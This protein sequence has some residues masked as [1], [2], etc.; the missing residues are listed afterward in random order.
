MNRLFPLLLLSYC[1]FSS[2]LLAETTDTTNA[3]SAAESELIALVDEF[4]DELSVFRS[5]RNKLEDRQ[6]Q[7]DYSIKNDPAK[8]YLPNLLAFEAKYSGQDVGIDALNEIVSRAAQG[9]LLESPAVKARREVLE[10]LPA[11][12]DRPLAIGPIYRLKFGRYDPLIYDYLD[13]VGISRDAH[14]IVSASS[15]YVLA[16]SVLERRAWRMESERRLKELAMGADQLI[17]NEED[18]IREFISGS[19]SLTEYDARRD[20]A[21]KI[22]EELA[23]SGK[24]FQLPVIRGVDPTNRISRINIELS[25][26]APYLSDKAAAMLFREKNLR[27]GTIAPN[28][29]VEL[30]N[31]DTWSSEAHRGQVIV[32]QFSFTGCGPCED[33][34]PDLRELRS[35]YNHRLSILSLMR[36][37][38]DKHAREAIESGKL[39][40]D[41]AVDGD[42][43]RIT[44][45]WGVTGFPEV[46]VIGKDGRIAYTELRD[47]A[48]KTKVAELIELEP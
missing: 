13:R 26:T 27:V 31:G 30:L 42:P 32:I 41:I 24:S 29:E 9:G 19:P 38:T 6:A 15:R 7:I 11:Y 16:I 23:D 36:D 20:K 47:E 2:V 37:E 12:E 45:R 25:K 39:T 21:I 22:L 14:P 28:L 18:S 34:Y 48:L 4:H 33:M 40:W 1:S 10:R 5:A 8:D 35:E 43:G 17:P 46:Y 3:L 44:A